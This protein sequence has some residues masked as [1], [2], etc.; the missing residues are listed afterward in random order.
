MK[1][2]ADYHT[3]SKNSRFLHGK[4]SIMEMAIAANEMGL[5]EIA[6][7]DHGYKHLFR[8]NK[9]KIKKARE[10]IDE[11][12]SWSKTKVLLGIEADIISED[13]T[14]DVDNETLSMLDLLVVGYHK[15]IKTDF[16]NFFGQT[17]KTEESKVRCT[18]AF[19]NCINRYPVTMV[20]HLDSILTT[21]MYRIGCACRDKNVM[22]E[23]NNRHTRWTKEQV[24]ELVA[25]GCLFAVCSDAHRREDVGRAEHAFN[26]IK[27]Y[28]IPTEYVVNV[29]FD[30]S[31]KTE[32]H[33]EADYYYSIYREKQNEKLGKEIA[34]EEKKLTEFTE[35]LSPEMEKALSEI[36]K[37]KGLKYQGKEEK[38]EEKESD[39]VDS[40]NFIEDDGL[41]ERA[42]AYIEQSK[43]KEFERQNE[44]LN[45]D[46]EIF[47]KSETES[48]EQKQTEENVTSVEN[49]PSNSQ[50]KLLKPEKEIKNHEVHF[51]NK[52]PNNFVS[53][54]I[55]DLEREDARNNNSFGET[56]QNS[57][58]EIINVTPRAVANSH[59]TSVKVYPTTQKLDIVRTQSKSPKAK[60][61]FNPLGALAKEAKKQSQV[62]EQPQEEPA[63]KPAQEPIKKKR[64][65][66][67]VGSGIVNVTEHNKNW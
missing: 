38:S 6:I 4:N 27:K 10:E 60:N 11:I 62:E 21:D 54:H 23:I 42:K 9:D 40:F 47:K 46:D 52:A 59:A 58:D 22:I 56:K 1:L 66:G 33:K 45:Q 29:E 61:D 36:A 53:G 63:K 2:F 26:I 65:G 15:M 13:G 32:D 57:I 35:T 20:S 41:I 18:N 50:E 34:E 51:E 8:T 67:F 12:N 14:I 43:L 48:E 64:S 31:E 3:H 30:E 37:E 28:E 7:T 16:A 17:P 24:D 49:E 19:V 55:S 44:F 39:F 5:S 25:S